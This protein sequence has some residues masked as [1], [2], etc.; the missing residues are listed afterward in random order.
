CNGIQQNPIGVLTDYTIHRSSV[1]MPKTISSPCIKSSVITGFQ[2]GFKNIIVLQNI[3]APSSITNIDSG[4]GC[5]INRT[6]AQSDVGRHLQLNTCDLLF[7]IPNI[8]NQIVLNQSVS[9]VVIGFWAFDGIHFLFRN[10]LTIKKRRGSY[11]IRS[12]DNSNC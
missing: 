8:M 11:R 6:V 10:K 12:S 5:S 3:S 7:N 1:R 2:N 4:T 9:R